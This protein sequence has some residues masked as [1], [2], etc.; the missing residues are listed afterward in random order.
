MLSSLRVAA[1]PIVAGVLAALLALEYWVFPADE[2][3]SAHPQ[4]QSYAAAVQSATPAVVNIYTRKVVATRAGRLLDDPFW[5]QFVP[6]DQPRQRVE[7]SL[8]SGVIFSA[9]GHIVTNNHVI[10]GAD[11]IQVLL[12]DG[13]TTAAR[14]IGTDPATDLALLKIDLPDLTPIALGTSAEARVGDVVLAIGNPLGFGQS[15]TQGIISGLERYGLEGIYESYIQTDAIIHQGNSGGALV[16]TAG[17]LVG[18]NTLIYTSEQQAAGGA[19]GIGIGLAIPVDLARFVVGDLI[20]YGRVIRGWL[21]VQVEPRLRR[22]GDGPAGQALVVTAVAEGGPAQKAGLRPGDVITHFNGEAVE[23]V[24]RSMYDIAL[25]RPG[26]SL[27]ITALRGRQTVD[28]R[29]VVGAQTQSPGRPA[30]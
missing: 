22:D 19:I 6:R 2:D 18:I 25:L 4:P 13:R 26:D 11:E 30:P 21:G 14:T 1:W 23:D 27:R 9:D 8:G 17:R 15:V 5:R 10:D 12:G 16:D 7:R 29:A 20:D 3:G 24:R 28:L